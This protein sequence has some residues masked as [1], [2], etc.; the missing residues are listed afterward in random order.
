MFE[1][2]L[3]SYRHDILAITAV[4]AVAYFYGFSYLPYKHT[5]KY[6]KYPLTVCGDIPFSVKAVDLRNKKKRRKKNKLEK[7]AY[8]TIRQ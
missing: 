6:F 5:F 2:R 3:S 7:W 4:L 1:E 8:F